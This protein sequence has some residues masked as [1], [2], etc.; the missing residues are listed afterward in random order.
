M[1]GKAVTIFLSKNDTSALYMRKCLTSS[2]QKT[3]KEK[4]CKEINI[5]KT[6]G[7]EYLNLKWK[8]RNK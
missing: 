6:T 5:R 7:N 3:K 1:V 8:S 2:M 4:T